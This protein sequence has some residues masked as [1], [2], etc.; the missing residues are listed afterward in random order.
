LPTS[1]SFFHFFLHRA[2]DIFAIFC[3]QLE[4]QDIS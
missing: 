1:K 4:L 3:Y 2:P